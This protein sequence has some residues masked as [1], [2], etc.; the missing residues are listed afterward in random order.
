[1]KF[2]LIFT[3]FFIFLVNFWATAQEYSLEKPSS[4]MSWESGDNAYLS[5]SEFSETPIRVKVKKNNI[6]EDSVVVHMT[7]VSKPDPSGDFRFIKQDVTTGPDG[8]A[9]FDYYAGEIS[10]TYSLAAYVDDGKAGQDFLFY[11]V[12]VRSNYWLWMLIFGILGGLALFLTGINVMSDGLRNALGQKLQNILTRS[13]NTTA[14]GI[15]T[16]NLLTIVTQSSSA[17]SVMLISF[18]ESGLMKFRQTI[19]VIMGAALGTTITI[20]LIAFRFTDYALILVGIGFIMEFL[21]KKAIIRNIGHSLLGIGLLFLGLY[22]MG[23]SLVPLKSYKPFYDALLT[24]ENPLAGVLAGCI[25]TAITQSS[26]MFI[27]IIVILGGQGLLS[28]E[29]AIPM[30]MGSNLG[31]SVTAIF[32]AAN[33]SKEAKKVAYAHTLYR[34]AGILFIIGWIGPFAEIIRYISISETT[35]SVVEAL[36]RQIA[37][38]HTIFYLIFTLFAFPWANLLAKLTDKIM[39]G[40]DEPEY[41]RLE[42]RYLDSDLLGTPA[43]ALNL[44]RKETARII[45]LVQ[46]MLNDILL[47]FL[48][49]ERTVLS[50]IKKLETVINFLQQ[51]IQ[52]YAIQLTRNND[53]EMII[54]DAYNIIAVS[55]ECEQIADIIYT[56][57]LPRAEKWVDNEAQFSHEG[58]KEIILFQNESQQILLAVLK[59]FETN[60]P[61][62]ARKARKSYKSI[63]KKAIDFEKSHYTRLKEQNSHSLSSSETHIELIGMLNAI[64]RHAA[65][66]AR[67]IEKSEDEDAE[68]ENGEML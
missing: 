44:A 35:H 63:A 62:A 22:I 61:K 53:N 10:G 17:V 26:S 66:I 45:H 33:R 19:G 37:N 14:K 12:H 9:A 5:H 57:L 68:G 58:K 11:T 50:G 39:P 29:A 36:P 52:N 21:W 64:S 15:L 25:F 13:T 56:N 48:T 49:K 4:K 24:L 43:I 67:F 38:S 65:N 2:H 8:I 18:V 34:V 7:I 3:V 54:R 28:L 6:P 20:Q 60:D 51:E 55:K 31:T 47:P 30:L 46:D 42:A 1:M 59:S 40:R 23:E 41:A 32:A 27:G 16:G